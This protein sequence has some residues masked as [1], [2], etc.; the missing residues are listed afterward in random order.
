M[1]D[2][3]ASYPI[4][5]MCKLLG[6]SSSGYYAWVKRRPSRRS[7]TD[8]ALITEIR[9]AHGASHGTYGAPRVH[10]ELAAKGTY[11]G[12][13]RVARLMTQAG[14]A[15]VSRRRFVI[16]T[17]KDGGRQAPDLVERNFTAEAPDRLWVADITYIPTWAGFLYLAVVLDAYSRRIVGWSMATT[18]ATQ[19][20][21]D[22]LNM[23]LADAAAHGRDPSLRPRFAIHL[24]RVRPPLPRRGCAPLDG[25]HAG[26]TR[27]RQG[28]PAGAGIHRP[29]RWGGEADCENMAA[30]RWLAAHAQR[31]AAL[32]PV[33][34]GDDQF[35]RQPL[36]QA[37]LDTGGHLIFVCK[38]SSHPLI[39]EYL[40]GADLAVL[41]QT[42]KRGKQRFVHRYRW[43]HD[44]PL[45]DGRDALMVNSFKIAI[46]N[47]R[48]ETTYRN[49]FVTDLAV[50]PDTVVEL[51]ACGRA[52]WTQIENETFN[53]L[54]NKGYN[55]EHSFGHGKQNLSAILVSLNLLAFAIHTVCDI[56]DELW[57]NART[58]LGPRYNFFG[59]LAAITAYLIF[60]SWD[61]LLL[62]LAFAKPPPIP[63]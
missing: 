63:P 1:S 53:V 61:D 54:K 34:L 30:K 31:Y 18:L 6:V 45:R 32:D 50:G 38:P 9:A 43:L 23:A 37:V 22:A 13:K 17:V 5:T 52:R 4:V 39:Q 29:A 46:I 7:E 15:G 35:S 14:L 33:Y 21:L 42:V 41:E 28:D 27:A 3:Q 2:H 49:S 59:K 58:K 51:A 26:G 44:V 40:T 47:D 62:T 60:P 12:R 8:A 25:G 55:L 10:A 36:C 57:R 56:G 11:I 16:T 48:G 20:V 24:D 19:L